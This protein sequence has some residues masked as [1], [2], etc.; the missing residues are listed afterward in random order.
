MTSWHSSKIFIYFYGPRSFN[1][2]LLGRNP[3]VMVA[4]CGLMGARLG[5]KPVG[6]INWKNCPDDVNEPGLLPRSFLYIECFL[7]AS[8][9]LSRTER[10]YKIDC[11]SIGESLL[12]LIPSGAFLFDNG[13][14]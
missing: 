6:P 12:T 5:M 11:M 4:A 3:L 14:R 1:C 10:L 8:G 13:P 9:V 7:P 2:C